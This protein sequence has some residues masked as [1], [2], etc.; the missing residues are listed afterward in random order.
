M[1]AL[2]DPPSAI[3]AVTAFSNASVVRISRGVRFSHTISTIR[4]PL[5]LAIRACDESAAG[6]DDAPGSVSPSA[7][8]A[9]AIVEAVPIVMHVPYERAM[10]SS[11]SRQRALVQGAGAPLGPVLPHVAARAENLAAPV[12]AQ[13]RTGRHHQRREVGAGGAHHQRRHRLVAAGHQDGAVGRVRAQRFLGLH[14]QQVAI[15]HRARLHQRFA[16][17]QDRDLHRESAG[18]PDAPLHFLGAN[19]EV[20]VARVGV[21]PRVQDRDDRLAA[22]VLGAEPGLLRARAMAERSQI[23]LAEPAIAARGRPAA[24]VAGSCVR[25]RRRALRDR[26]Q[27]RRAAARTSADT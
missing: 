9:A 25:L 15:Q 3:A 20:C 26:R 6:I 4:R 11:I 12:A 19:P 1:I 22:D 23:V 18:L 5:A 24:G 10:P 21:A 8:T 2:V 14:R 27:L 17:R 13:H 16:E 7:S